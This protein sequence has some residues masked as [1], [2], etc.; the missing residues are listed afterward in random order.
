GM[1]ITVEPKESRPPVPAF[2]IFNNG[3]GGSPSRPN[4]SLAASGIIRLWTQL[5]GI[6]SPFYLDAGDTITA[7][8]QNG[9]CAMDYVRVGRVWVDDQGWKDYFNLLDVDKDGNWQYINLSITVYGQTVDVLL[10]NANYG[11]TADYRTVTIV[12]EAGAVGIYATVTTTVEV[13]DG[14]QIPADAIPN[15]VARTGFYFA[16]WYPANPAEHGAVTEDLTFTARFNPLFHYVTF[17][18]ANGGTLV[19]A[20]GHGLTVR[21]RDGFTFWAD[22][23]PTPVAD[24]GYEFVEWYPANPAGFV[25][26]DNVTFTALFAEAAPVTP[27]ILSVTPNPATV[28][29]GGTVELVVTTQGMPEGA[30]V[31]LNVSWRPGLSIVGGPRFYIVD[32]QATITVAAAPDAHLGRDGFAVAARAAGQWGIPFV[33]DSYNFVIEV[34]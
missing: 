1:R 9:Q 16:G 27:Q 8:D 3:Y 29:P 25:V 11:H 28:V 6:N 7:L 32:N 15:V 30:W 2:D 18:A 17:E 23:V 21:I 31:D 5:D 12:V 19:P 14:G 24:D 34:Q 13:P 26:R 10:V 22:R 20:A 33:I 4:A